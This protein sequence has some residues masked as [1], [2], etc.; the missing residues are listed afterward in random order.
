[1]DELAGLVF[2]VLAALVVVGAEVAVG[3]LVVEQM[4]GDHEHGVGD[5][6]E[7][8]FAAAAGGDPP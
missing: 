4:P 7:S 6:D 3:G 8:V 5:R 2:G 1:M